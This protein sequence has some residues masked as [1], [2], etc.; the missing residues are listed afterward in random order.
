MDACVRRLFP[1]RAQ[2]YFP[3][4][5]FPGHG[6][7]RGRSHRARFAP[8]GG[9]CDRPAPP[10]GIGERLLSVDCRPNSV[11]GTFD[12]NTRRS[13]QPAIRTAGDPNSRTPPRLCENV[14]AEFRQRKSFYLRLPHSAESGFHWRKSRLAP[15]SGAAG[16]TNSLRPLQSDVSTQRPP[17]AALGAIGQ[18]R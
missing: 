3:A 8:V 1:R 18:L 6:Q 2:I 15:K 13:E 14:A 5:L 16:E 9:R 11:G 10:C 17:K 7:T 4:D 12:L